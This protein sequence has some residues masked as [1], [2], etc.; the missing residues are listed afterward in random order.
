MADFLNTGYSWR[1]WPTC[2]FRFC[3]ISLP[4]PWQVFAAAVQ[5][6]SL[7][8][9]AMD[10]AVFAGPPP[11]LT[12]TFDTSSSTTPTHTDTTPSCP[13]GSPATAS[14]SGTPTRGR[15]LVQSIYNLNPQRR[16]LPLFFYG[17]GSERHVA[18]RGTHVA[19][20][21]WLGCFH[22]ST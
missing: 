18:E 1:C 8:G 15:V 7:V 2:A 6:R 3:W 13:E 9:S 19:E 5:S 16:R 21:N 20:G 22:P 11:F 17:G 12:K 14:S 10:P 4:L